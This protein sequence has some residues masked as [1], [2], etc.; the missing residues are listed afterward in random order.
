MLKQCGRHSLLAKEYVMSKTLMLGLALLLSAT[1]LQAQ[2]QYPY[3]QV[4]KELLTSGQ[5][6]AQGC[7]QRSDGNYMLTDNAGTTYQ[8]QGDSSKLSEHAGHEVQ[9]MG[10]TTLPNFTATTGRSLSR[11]KIIR[12]LSM[13]FIGLHKIERTRS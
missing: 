12:S 7:L 5:T 6:T 13:P 9:I 4:K 1:W 10:T 8:V 2:S 3:T 11:H